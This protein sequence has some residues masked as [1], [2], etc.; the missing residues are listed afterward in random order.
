M[1]FIYLLW[2]LFITLFWLYLIGLAVLWLL[3]I[4]RRHPWLI[5]P[6]VAILLGGDEAF[7]APFVIT[8][9]V[10]T[11]SVATLPSGKKRP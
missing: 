6:P 9:T 10:V 5:I 3:G 7:T 11:I 2:M 8:L 4:I 1:E